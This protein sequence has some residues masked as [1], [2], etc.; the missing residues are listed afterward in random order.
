LLQSL[1]ERLPPSIGKLKT[2][3]FMFGF[4]AFLSPFLGLF[5]SQKMDLV[6]HRYNKC[7]VAEYDRV[8]YLNLFY[9]NIAHL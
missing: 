2:Q 8:K 5:L 3:A 6:Q 1:I 7:Y 4:F 9:K